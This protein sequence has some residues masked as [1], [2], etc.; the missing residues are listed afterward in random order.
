MTDLVKQAALN[1]IHHALKAAGASALQ[2]VLTL[3]QHFEQAGSPLLPPQSPQNK[4]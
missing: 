3:L 4:G 1:I 2:D